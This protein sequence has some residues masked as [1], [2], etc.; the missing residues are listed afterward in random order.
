MQKKDAA[1]AIKEMK[2]DTA[3]EMEDILQDFKEG[4]EKGQSNTTL[5]VGQLLNQ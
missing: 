3:R 5:T 1:L 2:K 4:L